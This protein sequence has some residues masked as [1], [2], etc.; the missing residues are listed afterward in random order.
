VVLTR[1]QALHKK[2][3]LKSQGAAVPRCTGEGSACQGSFEHKASPSAM[4]RGADLCHAVASCTINSWLTERRS[5]QAAAF[6]LDIKSVETDH[7]GE[8][9]R[10]RVSRGT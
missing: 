5:G 3:N 2:A 4:K 10:G 1:V 7:C 6:V 9:A 8:L